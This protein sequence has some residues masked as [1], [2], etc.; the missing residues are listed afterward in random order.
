[1]IA[2]LVNECVCFYG[3]HFCFTFAFLSSFSFFEFENNAHTTFSFQRT[4]STSIIARIIVILLTNHAQ[5]R[6]LWLCSTQCWS[7]LNWTE[8]IHGEIMKSQI[9]QPLGMSLLLCP[10][11]KSLETCARLS[12][13]NMI[14]TH[15]EGFCLKGKNFISKVFEI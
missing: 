12:P 9:M 5:K 1:M 6:L 15:P 7:E 10:P 4:K 2:A 13:S 14:S 8:L 3:A 11:N